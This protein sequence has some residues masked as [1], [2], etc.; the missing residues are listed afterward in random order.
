MKTFLFL[1]LEK[2]FYMIKTY[3]E[4]FFLIG[5]KNDFSKKNFRKRKMAYVTNFQV[6]SN[7]EKLFYRSEKTLFFSEKNGKVFHKNTICFCI[8]KGTNNIIIVNPNFEIE[9]YNHDKKL[10]FKTSP[11]FEYEYPIVPSAS[12]FSTEKGEIIVMITKINFVANFFFFDAKFNLQKKFEKQISS[13]PISFV[14]YNDKIY[15]PY[16]Y[17]L[18][19]LDVKTQNYGIIDTKKICDK[20]VLL[21]RIFVCKN[22][23]YF[24]CD[25]NIY[26][27]RDLRLELEPEI[28]NNKNFLFVVKNDNIYPVS[29]NFLK[30]SQVGEKWQKPV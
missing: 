21:W 28:K 7:G 20:S 2:I 23:L 11:F 22:T 8:Q 9:C 30:Y 26:R 17:S 16:F 27:F 15:I 6:E 3:Q 29:N 4:L 24:Q 5:R 19:I 1:N 18:Y 10:L 14:L 12:M 13:Y 25:N